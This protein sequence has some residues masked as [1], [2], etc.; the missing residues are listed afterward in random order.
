MNLGVET[1]SPCQHQPR[2]SEREPASVPPKGVKESSGAGRAGE[3]RPPCAVLVTTWIYDAYTGRLQ[4]KLDASSKGAYYSYY[5]SGLLYQRSWADYRR[6]GQTGETI[7]LKS[8][9]ILDAIRTRRKSV[10]NSLALE[11]ETARFSE[12]PAVF[13]WC[14]WMSSFDQIPIF[15]RI[16]NLLNSRLG[17]VNG[18]D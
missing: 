11:F 2:A 1:T 10:E 13:W 16:R 8:P 17:P 7:L 6:R 3:G 4:Q 5:G 12:A 14:F 15:S 9:D 18:Y